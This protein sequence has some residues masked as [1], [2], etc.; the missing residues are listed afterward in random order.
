MADTGSEGKI[1]KREVEYELITIPKNL[2]KRSRQIAQLYGPPTNSHSRE[3]ING[4]SL[5]ASI[6]TSSYVSK[7]LFPLPE[8]S[9]SSNFGEVLSGA[10]S[11]VGGVGNTL[12]SVGKGASQV[13]SQVVPAAAAGGIQA[14]R[15]I[16][17][18]KKEGIRAATEGLRYAG[19]LSAAVLRVL[20]QVPSIKA[21]VLSELLQASQPFA[22]AL[23]DVL[24]ESADDL[25]DIFAAKNDIL[26]EALE[27][28][29]R[30]IQDTLALKG[31]ILAKIGASGL[32]FGASTFNAGLRLGT[33]AAETSGSVISAL[34]SGVG[35]LVR[36]AT[37]ADFPPPPAISLP[38]LPQLPKF[39][40]PSLDFSLLTSYPTLAPL[41]LPSKPALAP[42]SLPTK[43]TLSPT[44]YKPTSP[45][46]LY[47]LPSR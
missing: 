31:R 8:I 24:A 38:Q 18:N 40:L 46:Q 29:I 21:R 39:S 28:F 4:F 20:L 43:P 16:T 3:N 22:Y 7:P 47:G 17:D 35:D 33:A 25:G 19:Q 11:L 5:P 23:S 2:L 42:Y 6:S 32:D 15:W 36:V 1:L 27:I 30:L 10:S 44:S 14:A 26:K 34:S 9:V 45:S 41:P 37:T 12:T 13:L